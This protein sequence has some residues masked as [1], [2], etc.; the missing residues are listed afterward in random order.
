MFAVAG[1]HKGAGFVITNVG[2]GLTVM[3]LV[4]ET[5][6]QPAGTLVVNVK[7]TGPE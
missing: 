2:E 3:F 5:A 6:G 4:A 1:A 7:T